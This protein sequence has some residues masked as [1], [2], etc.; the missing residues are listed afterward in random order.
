MA[1]Q[2]GA[3]VAVA[4]VGESVETRS[5]A[6]L[7]PPP[8]LAD[9]NTNTNTNTAFSASSSS[10]ASSQ[11]SLP[12][13]TSQLH[14]DDGVGCD[15]PKYLAST[16]AVAAEVT[17]AAA[18]APVRVSEHLALPDG[19]DAHPSGPSSPAPHS[20]PSR[21]DSS[22][23]A[24]DGGAR[25]YRR[26]TTVEFVDEAGQSGALPQLRQV[27]YARGVTWDFTSSSGGGVLA[28]MEK[29]VDVVE[30]ADEFLVPE[31]IS[32]NLDLYN[33]GG[34]DRVEEGIPPSSSSSRVRLISPSPPRA[35]SADET[36]DSRTGAEVVHAMDGS[37]TARSSRRRC[38]M[39]LMQRP[40][41]APSR[42]TVD[43]DDDDDDDISSSGSLSRSLHSFSSSPSEEGDVEEGDEEMHHTD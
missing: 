15:S 22:G 23:T 32:I 4:A 40:P 39:P 33:T 27:V 43:D 24:A 8:H 18:R 17:S 20:P 31:P 10:S 9:T 30:A 1:P 34:A 41:M 26:S 13:Q 7:S 25:R 19:P 12:L 37:D 36:A 28:A 14:N 2:G 6:F 42:A 29:E 38:T 3:E 21:H 16:A 35:V 11:A 5:G